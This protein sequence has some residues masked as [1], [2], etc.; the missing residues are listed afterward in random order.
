M[1]WESYN[2]DK[3]AHDLVA[4]YRDA[5]VLNQG[6]KMRTTATYG[7]ERFWGEQLRL[8]E[9]KAAYWRD[10]WKTFADIMTNAG[11]EIPSGNIDPTNTRA[12]QERASALWGMKPEYRK[13]SL[14]ILIQLCDSIVW[15]TQRYK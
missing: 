3:E 2:L 14:A 4:K 8:D 9:Q 13:V 12:I 6:Y 7:L 5:N 11:I 1:A 15:W 10:A